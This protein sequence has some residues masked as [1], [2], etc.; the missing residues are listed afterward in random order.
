M[1]WFVLFIVFIIV[2]YYFILKSNATTIEKSFSSLSFV[3]SLLIVSLFWSDKVINISLFSP[4][5]LGFSG[6]IFGWMG[7]KGDVR[8]SLVLLNLFALILYAVLF[9]V[10]SV[11]FK[12]P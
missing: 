2:S 8:V 7:I 12:E 6:I 1:H 4:F 9:F 3:F 5:F 10:A 11:G